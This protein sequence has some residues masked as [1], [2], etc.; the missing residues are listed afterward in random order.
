MQIAEGTP[1]RLRTNFRLAF[2]L[3][4]LLLL[5]SA[6][7]ELPSDEEDETPTAEGGLGFADEIDLDLTNDWYVETTGDDDNSCRSVEEACLT[8]VTALRKSTHADRVHVGAGTFMDYSDYGGVLRI[9]HN[10]SIIGAGRG[11]TILD[12]ESTRGGIDIGIF[13]SQTE[14]L[15]EGFTVQNTGRGPA[16]GCIGNTSSADIT[17]Q[18]VEL[19]N[20]WRSG[21]SHTGSGV[22][23][24]IDV[25]IHDAVDE[26]PDPSFTLNGSGIETSGEMI[27][28][29]GEIRDNPR[30]GMEISGGP[31]SVSG[32]LISGNLLRGV[33]V[34]GSG[35]ASLT[36]VNITNNGERGFG[37]GLYVNGGMLTVSDSEIYNN[38]G[39]GAYVREGV[40]RM[41][42]SNI[43]DERGRALGVAVAGTAELDA[44][45]ITNVGR[46]GPSFNPVV[47]NWG[48][49]TIRRSR[50]TGNF[51]TAIYNGGTGSATIFD[52]DISNNR[53][54]N[55]GGD[56]AVYNESAADMV[57]ARS[58][59]SN[60]ETGDSAAFEGFG[61]LIAVNV[62][63]SNNSGLGMWARAPF[64]ISY[65]T[66]AENDG[67]GAL[68]DGVGGLLSD[69]LVANNRGTD[70]DGA[71]FNSIRSGT[72]I[73]T[74]GSCEFVATYT[75]SELLLGGLVWL[76]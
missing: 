7:C 37:T 27:V 64:N 62:T 44:V 73:D 76:R 1:R 32:T 22:V 13:G 60:N 28:E 52:S 46:G 2:F 21:V 65:F 17:V 29:G 25:F 16:S 40:L 9:I 18:N 59:I 67:N 35:E 11:V 49:L 24:L 53:S 45:V 72:N 75:T 71:T 48:I 47:G 43:R 31:V 50:I 54:D 36:R 8:I 26:Y 74:D 70:C 61:P 51:R 12:G 38:A 63:V 58:L 23:H 66:I 15:L 68:F 30:N 41:N 69:V 3:M 6:G 10:I 4:T 34:Y 14:V 39:G 20:C 33:G 56:A 57:M 55:R 19:R 5:S 42:S